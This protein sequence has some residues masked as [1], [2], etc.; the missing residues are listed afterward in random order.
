MKIANKISMLFLGVTIMLAGIT[1]PILYHFSKVTLRKCIYDNLISTAASRSNQIKMF[2]K[3]GKKAIEQLSH[4]VIFKEFLLSKKEDKDYS[5]NFNRII[6]RFKNTVGVGDQNYFYDIF[7]LNKEGIIIASSDENDIGENKSENAYFLGA[8]KEP[9]IKDAYIS[10]KKQFETIAFS[11]PILIG[12]NNVFFGVLVARCSMKGINT[13]TADMSGLGKTGEI[14]LINKDGYMIT[15]SRFKEDTFLKLKVDTK[16]ARHCLRHKGKKHVTEAKQIAIS[17]D[18]RGI[19]VLGTHEYI[20]EMQWGLIAEIDEKEALETLAKM[21]SLFLKI[22]FFI[23]IIAWLIGIFV[24][25]LIARP[26]DKLHRG[27]E[28]IGDGNLDY[29]V[30]T[31]A[32]DEI[33][34]LSRAFDQMTE[35]LKGTTTSIDNLNKEI[36]ERKQTE[37]ALKES[38]KKF[39]TITENSADAIFIADSTGEYIYTN[40]A[41]TEL[42]GFTKEEMKGKTIIDMAPQNK[43][44]DH[45][46]IFKSIKTEGKILTEIELLKNDGTYISTELNTIILPDGNVYGSC[47]DIT[48]RKQAEEELKTSSLATETSMNAIFAA[49]LK[50]IITYANTSASKMWGYKNT[51]EMIGTN[52]IEYWTESTQ[53]KAGEMIVRLLKEGNVATSGVLTGKRLDGTEFIVESNSIII[54]DKNGKPVGLIGSFSDITER[55]KSEQKL[56]EA[57]E[58]KSQFIS[59]ASHELRTPLTAIKEG[60]AIVMDGSTGKINDEQEDFLGMAKRNVDRLARLIN[61]V[62]NFQKLEAGK[63]KFD[64]QA[65]DINEVVKEVYETMVPLTKEKGLNFVVKLDENLPKARFDNDKIIQVLTNIVNNAI[66]FTEKGAITVTTSKQDNVVCVAVQDTG[67]GVE[68]EDI[69]KLFHKFEQLAKQDDRKTGGT[70]LGLA[71]SKEIVEKHNGEIWAESK[72]GKGTKFIFTLPV[73]EEKEE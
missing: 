47:R 2:L 46:E 35:R 45:L 28:I 13:I 61:D 54:K 39:K 70:G 24:S 33:G 42:L 56:K 63:I 71:I 72:H 3:S 14:Y 40:K 34:Q 11:V 49:D 31:D 43:I 9:F 73:Q 58:I 68:K 15:T 57:M 59:M 37:E 44:N 60:I 38:E 17:L 41:V 51:E 19:N 20:D 21:K 30:G 8:K 27:T 6:K 26:I 25:R 29:K 69:Q 50:G 32:K 16:N 64:I 1:M 5:Q 55:K 12:K 66:K 4:G 65:K 22:L 18:Y 23:P 52:A 36:T 62:L 53:G 10:T 48:E 7:I 67:P